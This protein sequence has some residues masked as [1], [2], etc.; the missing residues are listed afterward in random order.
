MIPIFQIKRFRRLFPPDIEAGK[1]Q[2]S[3]GQQSDRSV[4]YCLLS[5]NIGVQF[6]SIHYDARVQNL[7][8]GT[9]AQLATVRNLQ[10]ACCRQSA[11]ASKHIV[12]FLYPDIFYGQ[13][14]GKI[15]LS[16]IRTQLLTIHFISKDE[17]GTTCY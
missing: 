6:S 5:L 13:I 4:L 10:G 16:A 8:T 14:T 7:N 17:G 1:P 3:A 11:L 2:R 12:S 9:K 15:D